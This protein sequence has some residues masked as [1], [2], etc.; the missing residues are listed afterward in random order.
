MTAPRGGFSLSIRR[1]AAVASAAAA[2]ALAVSAC[3]GEDRFAERICPRVQVLEYAGSLTEFAPGPGRDVTDVVLRGRIAGFRG[4][5]KVEEKSVAVDLAVEFSL[6][7]GPANRTGKGRFAHFVAIPEF[8]PAAV[9]KRVFPVEI[10]FE[11]GSNR[12]LFRDAVA[13]EIPLTGQRSAKDF[14]VFIG[15]Q[16]ERSQ[17]E[18]NQSGAARPRIPSGG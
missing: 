16:L 15:F 1:R 14:N 12:A 10:E 17:L 2:V 6:E 3:G 13:I 11:S 7:R 5:C 18:H 9:G 4:E 8:H